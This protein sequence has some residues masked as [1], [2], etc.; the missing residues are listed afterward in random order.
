MTRIKLALIGVMALVAFPLAQ[1]DARAAEKK[2]VEV[3]LKD[4]GA[5]CT[6]P[7]VGVCGS[8]SISCPVGKAARCTPGKSYGHPP[9]EVCQV[10]AVCV[11]E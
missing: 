3:R 2:Q 9:D 11:C 7:A 10:P 5:R 6:A 1:I 4:C 8:C